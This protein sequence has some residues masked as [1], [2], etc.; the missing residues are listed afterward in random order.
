MPNSKLIDIVKNQ[1]VSFANSD[2]ASYRKTVTDDV[3]YEEEGTAR[4]VTGADEYMKLLKEWKSAFPDAKANI[5][6]IIATGDAV[7][8]EVEWQA[9]HKGAMP[10][11]GGKIPPSNKSVRV[12]AVLVTRFDGDKTSS[13]HHYFDLVT[14]LRQIGVQLPQMQPTP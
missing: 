11:A 13:V 2:W 6:E 12:P 7:V 4:K 3:I 9:T 1:L 14:L 10:G 5:K 8:A